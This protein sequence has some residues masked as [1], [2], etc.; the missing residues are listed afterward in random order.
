MRQIPAGAPARND[1]ETIH[2]AS[3]QARDLVRQI[4][5]F[6]R[7]Q[8]MLD[9][10][11]NIAARVQE[12]LQMLRASVPSTI[13][14]VENIAPI[15]PISADGTQ[16]QQVV[17]NLVANGTH[18][19]GDNYGRVSV[20]LE[21]I[22]GPPDMPR[23]IQLSVADTGCGMS[24]EIMHRMFEPFFTTKSVGEG[25]GLGLSVVHGIVTSLGGQIDVKST[26]GEGTE[27]IVVLPVKSV[28]EDMGVAAV[29]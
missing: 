23:R 11:T 6:S 22:P 21:E 13:E 20:A 4:L 29:A 24:P 25:T 19:I 8:E 28:D 17:V 18:A 12:A 15:A 7:K 16:I 9:V 3:L 26:P 27:F 1:L 2:Q 10:P 5:A 14:I